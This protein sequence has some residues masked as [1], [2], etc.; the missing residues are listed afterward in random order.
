VR[1]Q[2]AISIRSQN[3]RPDG[4]VPVFSIFETDLYSFALIIKTTFNS[5]SVFISVISRRTLQVSCF[6]VD[7][8]IDFIGIAQQMIVRVAYY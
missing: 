5:L 8:S 1:G 4:E 2:P 3:Q 6:T 7:G